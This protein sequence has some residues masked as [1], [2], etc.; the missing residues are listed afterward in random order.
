MAAYD[1]KIYYAMSDTVPPPMASKLA[2]EVLLLNLSL[3]HI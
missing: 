3:I 2:N 1:L